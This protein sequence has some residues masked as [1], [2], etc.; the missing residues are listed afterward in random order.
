MRILPVLSLLLLAA[1]FLAAQSPVQIEWEK[2]LGGVGNDAAYAL[3][4]LIDGSVVVV[5]QTQAIGRYDTDV[6]VARIDKTGTKRWEKSFGGTGSDVARAVTLLPDGNIAIGGSSAA[7]PSSD[8]DGL[9]LILSADGAVIFEGRY[10]EREYE[11]FAAIT[12]TLDGN[13][14]LAGTK[15]EDNSSGMWLMKVQAD[16]KKMWDKYFLPKSIPKVK[17]R[18][19]NPLIT[20]DV[21]PNASRITLSQLVNTEL[22]DVVYSEAYTMLQN[23]QGE[24]LIAGYAPGKQAAADAWVI[25]TDKDGNKVWE[26][27]FGDVSADEAYGLLPADQG[28][29]YAFGSSFDKP[30][31]S[32]Q[33]AYL[34]KISEN[35]EIAWEKHFNDTSSKESNYGRLDY[36]KGGTY[37]SDG[38]IIL[39]GVSGYEPISFTTYYIPGADTMTNEQI[40]LIQ[41][42]LASLKHSIAQPNEIKHQYYD[43][44]EKSDG[45]GNLIRF[46]EPDPGEKERRDGWM[47][48]IDA[49]GRKRWGI[50]FGG[51]FEDEFRAAIRNADG[52]YTVVGFTRSK[53][54]GQSDAW[55]LRFR[56]SR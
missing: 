47:L 30:A 22:S 3:V 33:T 51:A 26:R 9:L 25:K 27:T 23:A 10:G 2:T 19:E 53:G 38:S 35:K 44:V 45:H 48:K 18:T 32:N 50:S 7:T 42:N 8:S 55:I 15:F 43:Y 24:L 29:F 56:D 20:K 46:R 5:G 21:H 31:T 17:S 4:E 34:A 37:T 54:S 11:S 12:A 36:A 6:W 16:G 52:S 39:V 41:E 1:R 40:I 49:A 13:I 28:F 14:A